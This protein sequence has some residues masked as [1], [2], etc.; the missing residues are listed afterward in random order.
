MEVLNI[1]AFGAQLIYSMQISANH[2]LSGKHGLS[3]TV[4]VGVRIHRCRLQSWLGHRSFTFTML[5]LWVSER[6]RVALSNHYWTAPVSL[7]GQH[8]EGAGDEN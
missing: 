6:S 4:A 5:R 8:E 1:A 7:L 2:S 3:S